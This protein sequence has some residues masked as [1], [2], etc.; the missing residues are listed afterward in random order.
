V[1]NDIWKYFVRVRLWPRQN[2]FDP[3]GWMS[4]FNEAER[5][6]AARLLEG[7]TFFS[8][9]LVAEM[10]RTVFKNLSQ[11]ALKNR[12]NYLAAL[13]EWVEFV[14][15]VIIVRVAGLRTSEADSGYIFIRLSRDVLGIA[16][17]RL[18][19]PKAAL[20]SL[21]EQPH[22][23]VVFVDDFVGS[24]EQF[25]EMWEQVHKLSDAWASFNSL[26][27][28]TGEGQIGFYY[29]PLVC[30]EQGRSYITKKCPQVKLRP[31]HLL[32]PSYSALAADSVIWREDMVVNGPRFIEQVSVR[33]GLHDLDGKEG[34]WRG[35]HK[36]GLS[37][38]FEHGAPDATLPIFTV[39]ND[40]WKPLITSPIK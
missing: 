4:N 20:E 22:Q 8:H 11:V 31:A 26:A 33:A 28:T 37:L 14:D 39:A 17:E 5:P 23:N 9:E 40:N 38:A 2:Q 12:S 19:S 34:C 7:F 21:R 36:L 32:A 10:F 3:K 6:F 15:S 27:C 25:V 30:A 35:Y 29:I 24:G 1:N 13:N 18:M 16:E